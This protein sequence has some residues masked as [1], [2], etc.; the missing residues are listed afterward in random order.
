MYIYIYRYVYLLHHI[1][2]RHPEDA[3]CSTVHHEVVA[4]ISVHRVPERRPV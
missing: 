2:Q 4:G 1:V 3:L